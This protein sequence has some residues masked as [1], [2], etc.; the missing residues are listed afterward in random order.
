MKDKLEKQIEFTFH[1]P[2]T[3]EET[4]KLLTTLLAGAIM[5]YEGNDPAFCAENAAAEE[6]KF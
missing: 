5:Q 6:Y 3:E 2:N 1:N 4:L